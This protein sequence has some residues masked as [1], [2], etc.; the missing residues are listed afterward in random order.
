MYSDESYES[1]INTGDIFNLYY[2]EQEIILIQYKL[3]G[4]QNSENNIV[5]L[6]GYN[7]IFNIY[8]ENN[9]K[10]KTFHIGSNTSSISVGSEW[11]TLYIYQFTPDNL[12]SY[13]D[14]SGRFQIEMTPQGNIKINDGTGWKNTDIPD[15]VSFELF[16]DGEGKI[17]LELVTGT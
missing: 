7:V 1:I 10:I 11:K 15:H 6:T 13:T 14:K 8:D 3:S 16:S 9:I 17:N 5:D 4:M 12:I 2:N